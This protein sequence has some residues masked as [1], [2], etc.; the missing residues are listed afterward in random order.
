MLINSRKKDGS[1][2][3]NVADYKQFMHLRKFVFKRIGEMVDEIASGNVEPNPYS[4]GK[5]FD[6]C[7]Y[8]PYGAVCHK[9]EVENIR[10]YKS[11]TDKQF[12]EEIERAVED[13]G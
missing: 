10:N 5:N 2:S 4:R 11:V 13:I 12:W 7:T 3:G 9:A 8:C 6:S 1:L